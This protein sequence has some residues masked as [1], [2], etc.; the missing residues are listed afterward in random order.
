MFVYRTS[1]V[2]EIHPVFEFCGGLFIGK[3][4]VYNEPNSVSFG[5][6]AFGS[7]YALLILE[8]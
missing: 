7:R 5:A 8:I 6:L 4:R 3:H 2:F 1:N